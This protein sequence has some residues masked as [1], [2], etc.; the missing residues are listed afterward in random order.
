MNWQH[1]HKTHKEERNKIEQ[2]CIKIEKAFDAREDENTKNKWTFTCRK[3]RR[4]VEVLHDE[5]K[6]NKKYKIKKLAVTI[7]KYRKGEVYLEGA[8]VSETRAY[9]VYLFSVGVCCLLINDTSN[10][11]IV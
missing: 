6:K 11:D 7:V 9:G 4:E 5:L 2:R 1:Q 10:N 8:S 3:T